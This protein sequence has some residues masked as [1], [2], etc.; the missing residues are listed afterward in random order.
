M[1]AEFV[2]PFLLSLMNVMS[3]MAQLELKPAP[4]AKKVMM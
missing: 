2:N 1:R 3:T 4:H